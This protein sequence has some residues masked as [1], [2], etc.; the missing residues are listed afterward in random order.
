VDLIALKRKV[1][2]IS[3]NIRIREKDKK[4]ALERL[5]EKYGVEDVKD[6]V[7]L[8]EKTKKQML[9]IRKQRDHYLRK[10]EKRIQEYDGIL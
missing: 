7:E 10:I 3:A 2:T 1:D 9:Q 8:M 4:K 5:R 6:A